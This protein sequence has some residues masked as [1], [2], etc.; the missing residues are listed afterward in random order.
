MFGVK[1]LSHIR[2]L[3]KSRVGD[4]VR[5]ILEPKYLLDISVSVLCMEIKI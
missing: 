2:I 1:L 3:I 5:F 4:G